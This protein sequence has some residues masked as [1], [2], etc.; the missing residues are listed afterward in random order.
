MQINP[1]AGNSNCRW[2]GKRSAVKPR[3]NPTQKGKSKC[4]GEGKPIVARQL[5]LI[6]RFL[7]AGVMIDG[8]F[9]AT[10]DGVPQGASLSPLLANVYFHYVLD[11]WFEHEVKPKLK[12]EAYLLRFADDF[13]ACFQQESDAVGYFDSD[14]LPVAITSDL[15]KALRVHSISLDLLI[16]A[17]KVEQAI[18]N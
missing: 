14:A 16:T 6:E 7:K 13:I 18:S 15:A 3:T 12:G 2:P 4:R 17:V 5:R 8:Q 9:K 11:Q 1:K 10:E